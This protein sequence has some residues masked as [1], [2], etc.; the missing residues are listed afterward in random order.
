MNAGD[1]LEDEESLGYNFV[2]LGYK[3]IH[4][5]YSVITL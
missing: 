4:Y 1:I 5:H 3:N 2:D